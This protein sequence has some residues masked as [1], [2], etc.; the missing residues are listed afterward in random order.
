MYS[1]PSDPRIKIGVRSTDLTPNIDRTIF[2]FN[3]GNTT[4]E[5]E[6]KSTDEQ[7]TQGQNKLPHSLNST[8]LLR[9]KNSRIKIVQMDTDNQPFLTLRKF[10]ANFEKLI[11]EKSR[12]HHNE[13]QVSSPY[14]R[15]RLEDGR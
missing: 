14:R 10:S 3:S 6:R 5:E 11:R 7:H 15:I 9:S 8:F 13:K 12:K 4:S 2:N 1:T